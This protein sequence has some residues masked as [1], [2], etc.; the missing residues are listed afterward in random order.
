M[1]LQLLEHMCQI[2][3]INSRLGICWIAPTSYVGQ[4]SLDCLRSTNAF[5]LTVQG[6]IP[7]IPLALRQCANLHS[8]F[9]SAFDAD[10][11]ESETQIL[12]LTARYTLILTDQGSTEDLPRVV[13]KRD[14]VSTSPCLAATFASAMLGF[15]TIKWSIFPSEWFSDM[16]CR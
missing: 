13:A 12:C 16:G 6:H 9:V 5:M 11:G 10:T 7:H 15:S 2:A 3:I 8:L 14:F 4:C 1:R